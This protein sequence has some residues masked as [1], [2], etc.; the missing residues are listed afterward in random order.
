ML[1]LP[2]E[3]SQPEEQTVADEARDVIDRADELRET[4][5]RTL[6]RSE[7]RARRYRRI[8]ERA[9]YLPRPLTRL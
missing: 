4:I 9:G 5:K 8:L 6:I 2:T 1:P 7:A 3:R